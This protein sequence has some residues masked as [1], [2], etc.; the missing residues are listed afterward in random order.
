MCDKQNVVRHGA[1]MVGSAAGAKLALSVGF[2]G[3]TLAMF[4][5]RH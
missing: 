3:D 1:P 2:S 5:F 4:L